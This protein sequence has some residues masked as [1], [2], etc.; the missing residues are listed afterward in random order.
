MGLGNSLNRGEEGGKLTPLSE[1]AGE[2]TC[3]EW[4]KIRKNQDPKV[5]G[6]LGKEKEIVGGGTA[7][8]GERKKDRSQFL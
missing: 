4:R 2:L 1:T 8:R 5:G 3:E 6:I 7:F